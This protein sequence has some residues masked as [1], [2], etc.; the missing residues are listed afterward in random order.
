MADGRR[1]DAWDRAALLTVAVVNQWRQRGETIA[2]SDVHPYLRIEA[3][4]DEES[5][6]FGPIKAALLEE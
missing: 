6:D 2:I 5:D 1:R 3:A 4:A